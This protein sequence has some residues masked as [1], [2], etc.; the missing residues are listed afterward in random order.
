MGELKKVIKEPYELMLLKA[1]YQI[2]NKQE[3][4]FYVLN[5]L[6]Q[7][8]VYGGAESDGYCVKSE[9][10]EHLADLGYDADAVE[11]VASQ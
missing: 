8:V 9:I 4:S 3:N 5:A 2:L 11:E 6:E 7:T 10:Y 1:C